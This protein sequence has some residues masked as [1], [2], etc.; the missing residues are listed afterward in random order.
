MSCRGARWSVLVASFA[1]GLL[2]VVAAAGAFSAEFFLGGTT[3]VDSGAVAVAMLAVHTVIGSIEGVIT[4]LIVA[5]V[6]AV[7]PDL[8]YALRDRI[9]VPVTEPPVRVG[10]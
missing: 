3:A 8:V 7:R 5:G 9:P 6:V 2:S 4:A 1:A 10:A